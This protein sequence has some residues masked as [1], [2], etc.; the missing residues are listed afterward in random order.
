[1]MQPHASWKTPNG[2]KITL[3]IIARFIDF[4]WPECF[5]IHCFALLRDSNGKQVVLCHRDKLKQFFATVLFTELSA[6]CQI[7]FKV[8]LVISCN[9]KCATVCSPAR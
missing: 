4:S 8:M 1:M 2:G 9:D 6:E 7:F 3:S 5:R